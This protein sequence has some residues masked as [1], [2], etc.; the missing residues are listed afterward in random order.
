M[1]A[2]VLEVP[3]LGVGTVLRLERDV[4]SM[5][6]LLRQATNEYPLNMPPPRLH[7]PFPPQK[8]LLLLVLTI[9]IDYWF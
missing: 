2:Q 3:L 6:K 8:L 9:S 1:S 4:W 7:T 5:V